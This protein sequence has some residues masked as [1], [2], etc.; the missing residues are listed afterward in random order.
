MERLGEL[1]KERVIF[2]VRRDG[3]CGDAGGGEA[4][5]GEGLVHDVRGWWCSGLRLWLWLWL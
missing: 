5:E 1:V 4:A 3:R 2:W